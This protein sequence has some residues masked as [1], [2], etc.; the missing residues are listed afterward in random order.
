[1]FED[2]QRCAMVVADVS[3]GSSGSPSNFLQVAPDTA[4]LI[5]HQTLAWALRAHY[6][7]LR[8]TRMRRSE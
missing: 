6:H 7:R 8:Q 5:P 1:M 4:A 2:M 3:V